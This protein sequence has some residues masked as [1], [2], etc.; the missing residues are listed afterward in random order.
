MDQKKRIENRISEVLNKGEKVLV[1]LLPYGDP[2]LEVSQKLV[3]IYLE[4]GVDIV[5]FA[6][7]SENPFVD[8]NQIKKSGYRALNNEP[9]IEKYFNSIQLIRE[10]YPNEPFEVMAYSD[11]VYKLGMENFVKGL[12]TADIDAHLLADSV[13]LEPD[14]VSKLDGLLNK[15]KISRIRFM[16]YPFKPDLLGDITQHGEG[17]MILQSIADE[18]GNRPNVAIDN[19]HLVK[20]VRQANKDV[21]IILAYGIRDSQRAEEA[22]K[23]KADGIIVGTSLVELIGELDFQSLRKKIKEIK[24]ALN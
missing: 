22:V 4:S 10:S 3:D 2:N 7:P 17:F 24:Q 15:Q 8:S 13:F 14:L 5:E 11:A 9:N 12:V 23:T 6:L 1:G 18:N 16:P 21:A 20:K 19:K